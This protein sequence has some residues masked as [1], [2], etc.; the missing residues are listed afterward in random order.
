MV[1]TFAPGLGPPDAATSQQAHHSPGAH[2]ATRT[3]AIARI[4]L[5]APARAVPGPA[6]PDTGLRPAAGVPFRRAARVPD[7]FGRRE[8][9]T[10]SDRRVQPR[11]VPFRETERS[12]ARRR[13]PRAWLHQRIRPTRP[14]TRQIPPASKARPTAGTDVRARG[15]R[16]L[17][18][19]SEGRPATRMSW[20]HPT[21]S[22]TSPSSRRFSIRGNSLRGLDRKARG[23][24]EPFGFGRRVSP[25]R[26]RLARTLPGRDRAGTDRA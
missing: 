19:R 26:R 15:E 6:T 10:V 22:S 11:S 2:P 13:V 9:P 25:F 14:T 7:L 21:R 18:P 17:A 24:A 8:D 23:P 1:A 20:L 12:A 3:W 5:V 4:E 16:I